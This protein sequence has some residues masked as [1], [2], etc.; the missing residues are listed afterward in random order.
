MQNT[1][2][3]LCS[4]STDVR[5]LVLIVYLFYYY[6]LQHSLAIP[7]FD[8]PRISIILCVQRDICMQFCQLQYTVLCMHCFYVFIRGKKSVAAA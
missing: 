7:N 1:E 2:S 3:L 8:K 4:K 6:Y 5:L